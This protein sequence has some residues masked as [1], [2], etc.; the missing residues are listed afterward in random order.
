MMTLLLILYSIG[1]AYDHA[2]GR[3][4]AARNCF[5]TGHT[6]LSGIEKPPEGGLWGLEG[7]LEVCPR[8][9]RHWG[10]LAQGAEKR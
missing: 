8:A 9:L 3:R 10:V 5:E 4:P 6:F 7:E 2:L 1:K